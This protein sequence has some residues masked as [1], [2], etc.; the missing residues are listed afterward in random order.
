[1][2]PPSHPRYSLVIPFGRPLT[3]LSAVPVTAGSESFEA[4]GELKVG[5][6]QKAGG[7]EGVGKHDFGL[8]IAT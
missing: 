5:G 7:K 8:R 6:E 3:F 4:D 2:R 1:M